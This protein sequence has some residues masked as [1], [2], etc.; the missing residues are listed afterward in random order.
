MNLEDIKNYC[1]KKE[2]AR[3]NFPFDDKTLTFI[4]G[5]KMFLLTDINSQEP[6]INL[7]CNPELAILLRE[8]YTA[9]SPGYHMNKK[10][11]NTI[12]LNKDLPSE[13]IYELI[14]HS[15]ELVFGSLT[16][17]EKEKIKLFGKDS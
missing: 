2:G 17:K 3:I 5:G 12:C 11:W 1:L 9:V 14:N 10:H 4:V 6:K 16:K 13:K 7:K 8:N 15:Y